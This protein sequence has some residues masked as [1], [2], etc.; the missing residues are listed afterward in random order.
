MEGYEKYTDEQLIQQFR[1]GDDA[2][3]DYILNKYKPLVGK[4]C[5]TLYLIGAEDDDLIQ[6]GMIGLFKAVRDY[7]SSESHFYH[8][9]RLCIDRQ[10]YSAIDK[11]KRKKH[12]PLNEYVSFSIEENENGGVLED[13]LGHEAMSP[14]Q[15]MIEQEKLEEFKKRLQKN[16]SGMENEVLNYYLEGNNY[17]QIADIMGKSP[18]AIDNALQRIRQKIK[19]K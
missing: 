17:T 4:E 13:F 2:V 6:E 1:D 3:M 18:K 5:N 12:Q 14:E 16:L 15:M 9:A 11:A 19:R 10:L 7:K 8:F